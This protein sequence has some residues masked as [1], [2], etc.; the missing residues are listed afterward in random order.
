MSRLAV[1]GETAL[2]SPSPKLFGDMLQ[3]EYLRWG[4]IVKPLN[5]TLD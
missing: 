4:A 1:G 5:L 3:A 2:S